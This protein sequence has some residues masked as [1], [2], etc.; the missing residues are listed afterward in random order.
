MFRRL[1]VY[2]KE[3]KSFDTSD[4]LGF[5]VLE[6]GFTF[7]FTNDVEYGIDG[8]CWISLPANTTS[9]IANTG[10]L[11]SIRATITPN[12][13]SGVG[14]FTINKKCNLEG[15]PLSLVYGGSKDDKPFTTKT[16]FPKYALRGLFNNCAKI[17]NANS[18]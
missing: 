6:D 3:D 4:Y 7:S 14:T 5:R 17:Q 9:E 13:S 8:E 2:Y 1:N 16:T 12:S 11:I 15:N 18:I 10:Q